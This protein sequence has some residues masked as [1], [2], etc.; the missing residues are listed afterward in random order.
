MRMRSVVFACLLLGALMLVSSASALANGG[1]ETEHATSYS[2]LALIPAGLA[3]L[4]AGYIMY[5]IFRGRST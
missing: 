5:R 1:D 2:P 4:V 3:A